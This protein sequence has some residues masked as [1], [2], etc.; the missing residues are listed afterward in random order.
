MRILLQALLHE[1]TIT[2]EEKATIR[3]HF[4]GMLAF[5]GAPLTVETTGNEELDELARR[6]ARLQ[7]QK[8]ERKVLTSLAPCKMLTGKELFIPGDPTE[9][10]ALALLASFLPDS[11]IVIRSVGLNPSRSGVFNALKRMGANLEIFQKRER[12]G[13]QFGSLRVQSCKR[14]MGR[15]FA[16]ELLMT[17]IEEVPLLAVAASLADGETILR[18]P[19]HI[20]LKEHDLLN[21]L[22]QNLKRA[23]VEVGVYEEGLVVRGREEVDANQFDSQEIPSVGLALAVLA[24]AAHGQSAITG[25]DCVPPIFPDILSKLGAE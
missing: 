9:A 15:K 8:M 18:L 12:Y 25:I 2:F 7:G 20:A 11:D 5:F 6:M 23:G 3:D 17:C 10:A 16:G 4:S 14:P 21:V 1:R 19:E 22:A 24:R 13:D